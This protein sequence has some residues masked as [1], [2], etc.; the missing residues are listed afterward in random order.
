MKKC[1]MQPSTL[2]TNSQDRSNWKSQCQEAVEQFE[3]A[4]VVVLQQK[5]AVRKGRLN[6]Q[7]T[8]V[9]G[10]VTVAQWTRREELLGYHNNNIVAQ[11]SP[12]PESG[13]TLTNSHTD[14]DTDNRCIDLN[15][16]V[17]VYPLVL[18]RPR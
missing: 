10:H 11:G 8:S 15:G 13:C 17:H 3:D 18:F 9:P 2:S 16:A 7:A 5:R 1:G 14:D 4:R 6:P 12:T